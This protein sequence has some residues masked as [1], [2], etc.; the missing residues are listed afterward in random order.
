[1]AT[2]LQSAQEILNLFAPGA[3]PGRTFPV[4][5]GKLVTELHTVP[6]DGKVAVNSTWDGGVTYAIIGVALTLVSG[7]PSHLQYSVV[8]GVYQFSVDDALTKVNITFRLATLSPTNFVGALQKAFLA[9]GYAI[10]DLVNGLAYAVGQ[11]WLSMNSAAGDDY[12]TY[13][14]EQPGWTQGGGT[15]PTMAQSAQHLLNIWPAPVTA[16]SSVITAVGI[17]GTF[18]GTVG[19]NTFVPEDLLPGAYYAVAQGWLRP[20]GL[21]F[22]NSWTLT[23]AGVA[24]VG[25]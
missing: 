21:N 11:G 13:T 14:L 5:V 6:T 8:G 23:A 22:Q 1:M 17:V 7:A 24:Q 16:N 3:R 19:G 4:C 15:A 25:S 20:F 12:Q 18:V 10:S 9:A 2:S